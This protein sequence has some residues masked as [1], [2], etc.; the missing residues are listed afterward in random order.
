MKIQILLASFLILC[1]TLSWAQQPTEKNAA[2][3]TPAPEPI[4]AHDYSNKVGVYGGVGIPHGFVIGGEFIHNSRTWALGGNVGSFNSK[5]KDEV[6]DK[7]EVNSNSFEIAGRYHLTQGSFFLGAGVGA[8]KVSAKK[9][10]TYSGIAAAPEVKVNNTFVIPKLGWLWQYSFGMNFGVELGA[11]VPL[12][13]SVEINDGT[14]NPVVLNNPEY[15]QNRKDVQDKAETLGKQVFPYVM[16]RL[17]YA[18]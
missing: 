18:F 16:L 13:T 1:S 11:Q 6:N 17:G 8:Q 12:T 2:P 9:T 5:L 7:E 3:P 14:T 10:T 15:V 4:V